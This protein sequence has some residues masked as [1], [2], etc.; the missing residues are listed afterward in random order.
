MVILAAILAVPFRAPP[1]DCRRVARCRCRRVTITLAPA[2][3]TI[4]QHRRRHFD[5][6]IVKY[7]F[8]LLAINAHFF[9]QRRAA[10]RRLKYLKKNAENQIE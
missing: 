6:E 3:A 1:S 7:F 4:N 8:F 2:V 9:S 5:A 10:T